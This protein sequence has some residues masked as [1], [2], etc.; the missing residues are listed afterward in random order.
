MP[1]GKIKWFNKEIGACFIKSDDGTNVFFRGSAVR[2]ADPKTIRQ[3]QVVC[4]EIVKNTRSIS[5]TAANVQSL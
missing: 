3:G 5:Q 4:F 2:S 1:T